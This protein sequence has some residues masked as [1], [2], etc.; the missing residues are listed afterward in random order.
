[1]SKLEENLMAN[2]LISD[3][4]KQIA[5]QAFKEMLDMLK[6]EGFMKWLRMQAISEDVKTLL[7]EWAN[8]EEVEGKH[9]VAGIYNENTNKISIKKRNDY[10][11]R[12]II[13]IA[14]HEGFHFFTRHSPMCIYLKEGVTEYLKRLSKQSKQ[15]NEMD[16][17]DENVKM[18][19]FLREFIGDSII[20]S[21]LTGKKEYF[22]NDLNQIL[23]EKIK[24]DK[25]RDEFLIDFFYLLDERHDQLYGDNTTNKEEVNEKI[26]D[27]LKEIIICKFIQM[28]KQRYFN[29]DG[30]VDEN[31]VQEIINKKLHILNEII[32]SGGLNFEEELSQTILFE[33]K[34][35][36]NPKAK[37]KD[38]IYSQKLLNTILREEHPITKI[39]EDLFYGESAI[40]FDFSD[41]M[42]ILELCDYISKLATEFNIPKDE[43]KTICNKYIYGG[44]IDNPLFEEESKMYDLIVSNTTRN[45]AVFDLLSSNVTR[46]ESL[47][48][49]ISDSEYVEDRDGKFVYIKINDDGTVYEQNDL[50]K[51]KHI[52]TIKDSL[53][54]IRVVGKEDD[55]KELGIFNEKQFQQIEIVHTLINKIMYE[56]SIDIE[57]ITKDIN[58]I[59]KQPNFLR[60]IIETAIH[61]R[62]KLQILKCVNALTEEEIEETMNYL[63]DEAML[64]SGLGDIE[65]K[66]ELDSFYE[67][68]G[69]YKRDNEEE[70]I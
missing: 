12:D 47:Y 69:K 32:E 70:R 9:G 44:I 25:S 54:S 60:L 15:V 30:I 42:S 41:E 53:E 18:V 10:S 43:L 56:D 1:M 36:C 28:A 16:S 65:Q 46:K 33:I 35:N 55:Y 57:S 49:K 7:I 68:L 31:F 66:Y 27:S 63:Y 62:T 29:K 4:F 5:R 48:R 37:T 34:R 61:K 20:K 23:S 6:K 67:E 24:E 8:E 45:S 3:E 58:L 40:V 26:V 51:V 52:F 11:K 59:V 13:G 22:L 17:Y 64:Q 14:K 39:F 21:Y 50:S 2:E 38:I 19:I